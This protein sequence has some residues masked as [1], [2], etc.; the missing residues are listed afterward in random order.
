VLAKQEYEY[1][2]GYNIYV[3]Q[4]EKDLRELIEKLNEK[5]SNN[6][7]KDEKISKLENTIAAIR[8]DQIRQER[9]KEKLNETIRYWK[10]KAQGYEQE[11]NFLQQQIMDAKR[12]NKLLKLAIGRLQNELE[13]KENKTGGED[14]HAIED[15]YAHKAKTFLTENSHQLPAEANLHMKSM[16]EN[17]T[18]T[19]PNSVFEPGLSKYT[20]RQAAKS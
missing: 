3:K 13:E 2:K 6:T 20:V 14:V 16:Q 4:K 17:T 18:T 8:E 9:E 5:N 10:V 15:E 1:L 11:K 12:Q 7:L 19:A